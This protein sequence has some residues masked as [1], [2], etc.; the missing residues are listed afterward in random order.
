MT[1]LELDGLT[2]DNPLHVMAALGALALTADMDGEEIAA[3][4][5]A[6]RGASY[7]PRLTTRASQDEWCQAIAERLNAAA[8]LEPDPNTVTHRRNAREAKSKLAKANAALKETRKA[9][10][11]EVKA[12]GLTGTDKAGWGKE[13]LDG[14][15]TEVAALAKEK[16]DAETA[17]A[18][19]LGFGPAHLGDVISTPVI[20]FRRHVESALARAPGT[21][22]QLSGLASDACTNE[23][24]VEP[25]PYSF[26]NGSS[27]KSLLKDFR[28]LAQTCTAASV[29]ATCIHGVPPLD[30]ATALNWDPRDQRSYALQWQD[31]AT[32][33]ATTDTAANA[34]A[35]FGLGVLSC[36]PG[37]RG[38]SAVGLARVD[39]LRCF[40]W[41]V[42]SPG[43][44]MPLVRALLASTPTP[45]VLRDPETLRARGVLAVYR[46]FII[47]PTGKRNFFA[48]ATP[49]IPG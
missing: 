46:S 21:A 4:G 49:V 42:W 7:F 11:A 16:S 23:D 32:A 12:R 36:F 22:R 39:N 29:A 31:P 24:N 8:R 26:S 30:D 48:P 37:R 28:N 2:G 3:L 44:P 15:R 1:T 34:L 19:S 9:I 43:L 35:F 20:A 41:P 33:I 6:Q 17:L 38:L 47:N 13:R 5:W 27:G 14:H 10:A 45:A 18:A 40:T 25:T